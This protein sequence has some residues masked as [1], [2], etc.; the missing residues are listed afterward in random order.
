MDGSGTEPG[1]IQKLIIKLKNKITSIVLT[2]TV[3]TIKL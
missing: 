2:V 1:L 3:L